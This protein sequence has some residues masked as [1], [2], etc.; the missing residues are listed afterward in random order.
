MATTNGDR[1]L[2]VLTPQPTLATPTTFI[3]LT[4]TPATAIIASPTTTTGDSTPDVPST[5]T[6]TA[7][8]S[9]INNVDPIATW[10]HWDHTFPSHI[11]LVGRLRIHPQRLKDQ[12]LE[13]QPTPAA[14]A[15]TIHTALAYSCTTWAYLATCVSMRAKLTAVPT[16]LAHQAHPPCLALP[17]LRHPSRSPPPTPSHSVHLAHPPCS[18]QSTHSRPSHSPPAPPSHTDTVDHSC[19]HCPRIF[20]SRISLVGHLRIHRTQTG[21]PVP[22]APTYARRIRLHCPNCTRTFIHCMGLLGHMRA[23]VNLR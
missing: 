7:T 19:P 16:H 18:D 13:H 11:S 20:T 23:H 12:F 15:S 4:E 22:G 1:A 9:I 17:T 3:T 14:F 6:H 21:E 8:A 5:T 2:G 10:L